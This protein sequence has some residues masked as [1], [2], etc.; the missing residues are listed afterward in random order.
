[1][2]LTVFAADATRRNIALLS[3]Q[4][5][6]NVLSQSPALASMFRGEVQLFGRTIPVP[7]SFSILPMTAIGAALWAMATVILCCSKSLA[8]FQRSDQD[9]DAS[10]EDR[11][12]AFGDAM[13]A[14]RAHFLALSLVL[15]T[16]TLATI[17]FFRTPLG[18]LRSVE[19]VQ[20]QAVSNAMGLVWGATFSLTLIALC[21]YPFC[22]LRQRFE[23]LERDAKDAQNEPLVKW[24][25][26]HRALLQVPANLKVILSMLTPATISVLSSLISH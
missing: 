16:S 10:Q 21:V 13:E 2:M 14:L 8:A 22:V 12:V 9:S 17:A 5:I 3:H 24:I 26:K 23:I 25:R 6:F 18:I 7:T 19:R 1:L 4:R 11:V 15:V 20:Y